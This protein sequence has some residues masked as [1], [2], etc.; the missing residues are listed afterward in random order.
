MMKLGGLGY[1][2]KLN[3]EGYFIYA[4][5]Q[6]TAQVWAPRQITSSLPPTAYLQG[7]YERTEA[8]ITQKISRGPGT[9]P[10]QRV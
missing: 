1:W 10:Q 6:S 5:F 3:D 9:P 2:N 7:V 8:I 4:E